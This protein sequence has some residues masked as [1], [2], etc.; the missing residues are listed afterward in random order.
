MEAC[1]MPI[2]L[3]L[4]IM[5]V[6]YHASARTFSQP[7]FQHIIQK[8]MAKLWA[9]DN[10]HKLQHRIQ[11]RMAMPWGPPSGGGAVI[12]PGPVAPVGPPITT[13]VVC[14]EY[15]YGGGYEYYDDNY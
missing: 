13:C 11:K 2:L 1:R 3:S 7:Q 6:I 8:R 5:M 9:R 12:Q 14:T 10:V 4:L 15:G